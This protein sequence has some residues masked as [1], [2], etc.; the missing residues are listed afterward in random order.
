MQ[1]D[2]I[3]KPQT[4]TEKLFAID[5]PSLENLSYAL[6]HPETWPD[7]F[8]WDYRN[9]NSCAMGLASNL[10]KSIPEPSN[11]R[12]KGSSRMARSF[13][14][15]YEVAAS[16]FFGSKDWTPIRNETKG[17]LWWKKHRQFLNIAA[18]TPEMVADQIDKYIAGAR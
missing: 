3:I 9:C 12:E 2:T 6:R 1:A 18:V 13:S 5:K 17:M 8:E 15:P 7:G 14:L 10:W 4:E 11:K 16:I